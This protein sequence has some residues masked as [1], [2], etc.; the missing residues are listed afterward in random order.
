MGNKLKGLLN[1]TEKKKLNLAFKDKNAVNDFYR[2]VEKL[3]ETGKPQ[4]VDNILYISQTICTEYEEYIVEEHEEIHDC[5]VIPQKELTLSFEKNSKIEYRFLQAGDLLIYDPTNIILRMSIK[6]EKDKYH[7]TY[8]LHPEKA[9][10][11]EILI[12]EYTKFL[13][14]IEQIFMYCG[15]IVEL[16]QYLKDAIKYYKKLEEVKNKLQITIVPKDINNL[17]NELIEKLYWALVKKRIIRENTIL[18]DITSIDNQIEP[19]IGTPFL[20]TYLQEERINILE[21]EKII[22]VFKVHF[23]EVIKDYKKINN[24]MIIY[25]E[26]SENSAYCASSYFLDKESA[27][28]EMKRFQE[29]INKN[30]SQEYANAK[31]LFQYVESEE[32][33]MIK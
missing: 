22:W 8:S 7:V 21:K 17:D 29:N 28:Q 26:E 30:T 25:F 3:N 31:T 32:K 10:T 14:F 6:K 15:E 24:K 12:N 4:N 11:L 5:K 33:E 1:N 27:N 13:Y 16:R 2:A 18:R 19:I 20:I 9:S 23:N